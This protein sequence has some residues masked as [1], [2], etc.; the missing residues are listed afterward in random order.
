[1]EVAVIIITVIIGSIIEISE[2]AVEEDRIIII[3]IEGAGREAG[4][5]GVASEI[6]GTEGISGV[7]REIAV[8]R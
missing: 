2:V 3:I 8:G 7:G 6:T 1:M 5:K 4:S